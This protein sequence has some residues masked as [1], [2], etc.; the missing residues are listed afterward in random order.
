MDFKTLTPLGNNGIPIQ[1]LIPETLLRN[2]TLNNAGPTVSVPI[3]AT[4]RGICVVAVSLAGDLYMRIGR[5]GDGIDA[6]AANGL[7]I[8]RRTLNYF[9]VMPGQSLNFFRP[10]GTG[11]DN[12]SVFLCRTHDSRQNV[13]VRSEPELDNM[14]NPTGNTL[15][16]P[17]T[18]SV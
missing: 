4:I 7:F 12:L 18:P 8:P 17:E 14:D 10:N 2:A 9:G 1:A 6:S 11:N 16:V 5:A 3:P 13:R 15:Y